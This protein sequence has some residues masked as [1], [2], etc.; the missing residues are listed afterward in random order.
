MR[1]IEAKMKKLLSF[2]ILVGL[3]IWD[4]VRI[5]TVNIEILRLEL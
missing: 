3:C 1:K 5:V 2:A 4:D